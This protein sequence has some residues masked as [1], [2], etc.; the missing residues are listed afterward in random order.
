[1]DLKKLNGKEN[2][3]PFSQDSHYVGQ[4]PETI[5][6]ER[7]VNSTV[8]VPE[9]LVRGLPVAAREE[10]ALERRGDGVEGEDGHDERRHRAH[11]R[12]HRRVRGEDAAEEERDGAPDKP[13]G[14]PEP[15]AREEEPLDELARA[16]GEAAAVGER[17]ASFQSRRIR[18]RDCGR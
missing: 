11:L 14:G 5:K 9:V 2:T 6:W 3:F 4:T 12:R 8:E 18:F 13:V 17:C 15:R 16:H 10:D 7:V 1:M